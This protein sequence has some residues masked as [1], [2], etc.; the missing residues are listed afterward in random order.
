MKRVFRVLCARPADEL[1]VA[2]FVVVVKPIPGCVQIL[3]QD[4]QDGQ[5]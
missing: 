4:E 5:D 2:R 3:G 1:G